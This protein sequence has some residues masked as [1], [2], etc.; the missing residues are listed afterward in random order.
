MR[1][2]SEQPTSQKKNKQDDADGLTVD[3]QTLGRNQSCER[4]AD[5]SDFEIEFGGSVFFD[6]PK[7]LCNV[8]AVADFR[9]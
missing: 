9:K 1:R 2:D 7:S 6:V 3:R 5:F 8:D 4:R